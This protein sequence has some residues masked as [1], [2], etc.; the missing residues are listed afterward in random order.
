MHKKQ[1]NKETF[2]NAESVGIIA[3]MSTLVTL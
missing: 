3:V 2:Y 1:N